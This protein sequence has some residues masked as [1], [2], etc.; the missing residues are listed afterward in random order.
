MINDQ[1]SKLTNINN[2]YVSYMCGIYDKQSA[3]FQTDHLLLVRQMYRFTRVAQV[4]RHLHFFQMHMFQNAG[5]AV[6]NVGECELYTLH[7]MT[8]AP[9]TISRTEYDKYDNIAILQTTADEDHSIISATDV[10][11]HQE[12]HMCDNTNSTSRHANVGVIG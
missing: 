6:N 12:L 5:L 3:I 10:W 7:I 2:Y 8:N 1:L 9:R 4:R 11:I